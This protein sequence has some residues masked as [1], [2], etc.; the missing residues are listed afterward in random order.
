MALS[1]RVT[2]EAANR[3]E[4]A[5]I[6]LAILIVLSFFLGGSARG[7]ELT[8]LLLRP[9]SVA[10]LLGALYLLKAEHVR[11][12][13]FP[14]CWLLAV[15]VLALLHLVPLPPGLWELLPGRA[16]VSQIDANLGM[17][18]HWRPLSLSP[19]LTRNALW[20]MTTPLACFFLAIQL[21][22]QGL[23]RIFCLIVGMA[24]LS[25][26][27]ATIQISQGPESF[28]YFYRITSRGI[29][30]G[31]FANRNHQAVLLACMLP[32]SFGLLLIALRGRKLISYR[33]GPML[34]MVGVGVIAA[35]LTI[36]IVVTGSRSGL[37]LNLLA[38]VFVILFARRNLAVLRSVVAPRGKRRPATGK[39][40]QLQKA[41]I[42]VLPAIVLGALLL[43]ILAGQDTAV[44]RLS[45]TGIETEARGSIFETLY[46]MTIQYFPFGSGIGSFDPVFRVHEPQNLLAPNY[47]N[48]AHNDWAEIVLTAGLPA[49]V[50][51]AA[52]FWFILK[53]ARLDSVGKDGDSEAGIFRFMALSVGAIMMVSS[54]VE[55][56]LRTPVLSGIFCICI[57]V[58]ALTRS[59]SLGMA[60]R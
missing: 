26:L 14:T 11:A 52:G 2:M 49:I 56:P 28:L 19:E 18:S 34:A 31:F 32:V 1:E 10:I 54:V 33:S 37:A 43:A 7:D 12:A 22:R 9:A 39:G 35:F 50:L 42:L 38:L 5:F 20:S 25:G 48:H 36:L 21:S 29:G 60:K 44:Q 6:L 17:Q 45:G 53:N 16:L 8:V 46:A 30:V 3:R 24:V 4:P 13:L 27:V 15:F 51:V 59:G 41:L 58:I 40:A 23:F 57:A 47:W 55:Y